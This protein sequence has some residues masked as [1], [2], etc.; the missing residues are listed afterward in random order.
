M[1]RTEAIEIQTSNEGTIPDNPMLD[2]VLAD[3]TAAETARSEHEADWDRYFKKYMCTLGAKS[4]KWRSNIFDPETFSMVETIYPRLLNTIAGAPEVFGVKPTAQDDVENAQA[5]EHLLNYQADRMDLYCA[6]GDGFKDALIYGTGH[7]LISWRREFEPR[8]VM[9]DEIQMEPDPQTG[10]PIPV[11]YEKQQKDFV[12]VYDDPWLERLDIKAVYPDPLGTSIE[13]SRFIIHRCFRS[14]DY[15]KKKEMEGVYVDID[16]IPKSLNATEADTRNDQTKQ[17]TRDTVEFHDEQMQDVEL[18]VY[19]GKYDIDGD[20]LLEEAVITVAN[21]AVVITN[22]KD[23]KKTG[24][25]N[26]FPGGQKPFLKLCLIPIPGS[27]YGLSPIM[28]ID[29]LQDNLNERINQIGDN[30]ELAIHGMW[31]MVKWADIDEDQLVS[32]PG[33]VVEVNQLQDLESLTFPAVFQNAYP[34]IQRIEGKIQ[35]AS[36]A[37]DVVRGMTPENQQT[38]TTT[39][40]LANSGEIRF[41]TMMMQIERQFIRP[42]G[43]WMIRLN[44]KYMPQQKRIRVLGNDMFTQQGAQSFLTVSKEM[45]VNN[46]DIYAVGAALEVGVNKEM[47]LQKILQ[48]LQIFTNPIFQQ[49][50]LKS[51]DIWAAA[52]QVPYLMNLKLKRPLISD[53]NPMLAYQQMMM[54]QQIANQMVQQEMMAGAPPG[55]MATGQMPTQGVPSRVKGELKKGPQG[56]DGDE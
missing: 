36:G 30:L 11:L 45:L 14:R 6:G 34:E 3:F 23:E 8:Y 47:Q 40:T 25:Y 9:Q 53:G 33:G 43:N 51:V 41:K 32:R 52:E 16:K 49:N 4:A 37:F 27:Y 44:D 56:E 1:N 10:M 35:K 7:W 26:P 2:K 13:N 24:F 31:K 39:I 19:Y 22:P 50:P 54:D 17:A 46:P 28:P 55:A 48:V 42:L 38:A 5:T 12:P 15:L 21:R 18:L 29:S 20:G